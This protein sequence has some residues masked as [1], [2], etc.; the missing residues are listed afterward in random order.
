MA[1]GGRNRFEGGRA[2]PR[3]YCYAVVLR[4]RRASRRPRFM[5]VAGQSCE[6]PAVGRAGSDSEAS[7][8]FLLESSRRQ[9]GRCCCLLMPTPPA[10]SYIL[11]VF[12]FHREGLFRSHFF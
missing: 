6:S 12:S 7:R 9:G 10:L 1:L 3:F 11:H 2:L 8:C 4:L 5:D